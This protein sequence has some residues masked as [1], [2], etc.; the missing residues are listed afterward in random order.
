[1][2]E[3][4]LLKS[5]PYSPNVTLCM[6]RSKAIAGQ[7]ILYCTATRAISRYCPGRWLLPIFFDLN[8]DQKVVA[9]E[10]S[11]YIYIQ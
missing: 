5:N 4:S 6:G 2:L 1:M 10:F 11:N 3:G 7:Y 8:F 9:I